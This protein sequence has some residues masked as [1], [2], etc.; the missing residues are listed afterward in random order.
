M[1]EA[2]NIIKFE[3]LTKHTLQ[4]PNDGITKLL[5]AN[6]LYFNGRLL[7]VEEKF[8]L[9]NVLEAILTKKEV[10]QGDNLS[11]GLEESMVKALIEDKEMTDDGK[12]V[13]RKHKQLFLKRIKTILNDL[14]RG[15][16]LL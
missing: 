8:I 13:T 7:T 9:R 11:I 4:L 10:D 1:K 16:E 5:I 15:I 3:P 6:Q 14:G 12:L 2:S